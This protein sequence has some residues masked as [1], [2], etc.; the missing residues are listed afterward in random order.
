MKGKRTDFRVH[1]ARRDLALERHA[2][3]LVAPRPAVDAQLQAAIDAAV[4]AGRVTRLPPA[5]RGRS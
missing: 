1:K 3:Q 5:K 2:A 4:A